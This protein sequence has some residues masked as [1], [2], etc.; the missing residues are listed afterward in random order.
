MKSSI[1]NIRAFHNWI[2]SKLFSESVKYLDD[3]DIEDKTLLELAVGKGGDMHKWNNNNIKTVV[4]FDI[5]SESINGKNGAIDRYNS[6]KHK[7]K[8][9]KYEYHVMDLSNPNNLPA[10]NMIIK[11]RRFTIASC[12]FAL[13]YF[14]KTKQTLETFLTI[15]SSYLIKGGIFIGTT[16]DGSLIKDGSNSIYSIKILD[17][18]TYEVQLGER[19]EDHYFADKP[20]IEYLVD[21]EELKQMCDKHNLQFICYINFKEWY[22]EY[23]TTPKFKELTSDEKE[24]SFVNFSFCF[25]KK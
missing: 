20:S 11:N 17:K 7:F 3:N 24:Y 9:T 15:V 4:G 21:T 12:Q 16:L 19:G 25:I 22:E 14:F 23:K 5:S 10:I 8:N 18:N 1:D 2:K 6:F 13:H